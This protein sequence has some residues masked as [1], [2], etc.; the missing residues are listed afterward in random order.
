MLQ[1]QEGHVQRPR[2]TEQLGEFMDLKRSPSGLSEG[3]PKDLGGWYLGMTTG[4]T[5][6]ELKQEHAK[7]AS[8]SHG[9]DTRTGRAEGGG[10]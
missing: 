4:K 5:L 9:E 1:A 6:C 10:L 7:V 3:G 2:G 8:L